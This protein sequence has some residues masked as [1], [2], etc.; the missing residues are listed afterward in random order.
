MS[1]FFLAVLDKNRNV[2]FRKNRNVTPHDQIMKH[3]RNTITVIASEWN[4][5][6]NLKYKEIASSLRFSQ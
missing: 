2:T 5:R 3:L 4:E 1:N 6:G